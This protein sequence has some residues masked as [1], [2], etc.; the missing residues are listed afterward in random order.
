MVDRMCRHCQAKRAG[1]P[2]GLCWSCFYT[3]GVRALYPSTS[4]LA[5]R[6]V[7]NRATAPADR[8]CEAP[9]GTEEKIA[10]LQRR[11]AMEISLYHPEDARGN[12]S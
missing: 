9:P 8:P 6:G 11:A 3:P 4:R 7:G 1:K 10:E 2:R 12:L 5:S